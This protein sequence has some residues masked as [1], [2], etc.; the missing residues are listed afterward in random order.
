MVVSLVSETI[1]VP[2]FNGMLSEKENVCECCAIMKVEFNNLKLELNS[3]NE[4]IRILQEEIN[5]M[6][7]PTLN[8][9]NE[10]HNEMESD[11]SSSYNKWSRCSLNWRR[12]PQQIRRNLQRSPLQTSDHFELLAN[13]NDDEEYPKCLTSVNQVQVSNGLIVK[14]QGLSQSVKKTNNI[15]QNIVIIG[16]SHARN[17][18][19]K[20]HHNLEV[21]YIQLWETW[22][23]NECDKTYSERRNR[24]AQQ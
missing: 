20:L 9:A 24:K 21:C 3:C 6:A 4:I 23:W 17:C 16:D 18:A 11:N 19:A 5:K 14:Y 10:D 2:D 8:K 7:Q 22:C 15:K 1:S 13:L 12:K